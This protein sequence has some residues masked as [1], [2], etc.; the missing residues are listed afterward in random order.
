MNVV[1]VDSTTLHFSLLSKNEKFENLKLYTQLLKN[2]RKF[3]KSF[4]ITA[5]NCATPAQS[6]ALKIEMF[7]KVAKGTVLDSIEIKRTITRVK[8]KNELK[9]NNSMAKGYKITDDIARSY[10]DLLTFIAANG[11]DVRYDGGIVSILGRASTSFNGTKTPQLFI[12]DVPETNFNQLIGLNLNTID[13]I[14]ISKRGYGGGDGATNG[15]IRVYN[16]KGV[17]AFKSIEIKSKSLLVQ[18]GFQPNKQF[19]NPKYS[20]Y[21]DDGFKKFGTI[22][23]KQAIL[24]DENG[25]FKF[26]VPNYYKEGLKILIEGI[27]SEGQLISETRIIKI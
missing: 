15:V 5:S 17:S 13:E 18:N 3:I 21:Y 11:F 23:F 25:N 27:S 26:S 16:R 7:P 22:S 12:N 24:I 4:Q 14:Y 20:N 8:L 2:N 1:A 19:K 10:Y 6:N 9:F